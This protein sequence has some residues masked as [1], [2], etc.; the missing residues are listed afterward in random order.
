M[1]LLG[2]EDEIQTKGEW[3]KIPVT[4]D[5]GAGESVTKRGTFPHKIKNTKKTGFGYK[6][7]N[8]Q[9]L[10]NEGEQQVFGLTEEGLHACI[11]FQVTDVHKSLLAVSQA[12][13]MDNTVVSSNK[14]CS[15]LQDNKSGHRTP[16]RRENGVYIF[17]LWVFTRQE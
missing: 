14:Y 10:Y 3:V 12:T 2:F 5:S 8:D 13:D 11:A 15:S 17:G 1:D 4:V 16:L 9:I 7:A 6:V